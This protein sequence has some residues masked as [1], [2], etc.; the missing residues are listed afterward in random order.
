MVFKAYHFQILLRLILIVANCFLIVYVWQLHQYWISFYNLLLFLII[1]VYLLFRY[2]TRWQ[3][4]VKVFSNSV[5]HGDYNITYN[6]IDKTD[7][8]YDLYTML[9]SISVYVR[10]LKSQSEQ[11]N[12]YFQ[13]LVENAQ[14]GLVAYD[15]AGTIL[16]V[17]DEALR[18]VGAARLKSIHQLKDT[19]HDLYK[20]LSQMALRQPKLIRFGDHKQMK[21]SARLSEVV[22]DGKSIRLLSLINIKSELEEN[23]LQSWQDLISVLTHELMNSVT[24]INSLGGSMRKYLDRIVDNEEIVTK[25]KS[26][27]DVITRRSQ[28]LM[29][30]VDRYRKISAVPLPQL[31]LTDLGRLMSDVLLLLE[32]ELADI[33]IEY[34]YRSTLVQVDPSMIE[35]VF[36]N[37]I[38][39]A[40]HA[41]QGRVEK[42]LTILMTEAYGEVIVEFS[43]NGKG[44]S[45]AVM[46]KIFIPFFTTREEG[47][48]IGLTLSRQIIHR[49]KGTIEVTSEVGK[50][51]T[52]TL[53]FSKSQVNY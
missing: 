12:H 38:K 20:Q 45:D 24:P 25:A 49:H 5:R 48:G 19:A 4:D 29:N 21:L 11:Q 34:Q 33:K 9:N 50:G 51:A 13:Y 22:I 26:S 27:L 10:D 31:R 44:I 35:Q 17:N 6:L 28:M 3:Q 53:R 30:F 52:F 23:E 15:H 18:L 43:D 42:R 41:L 37:L 1:Q 2:L 39:N 14:V 8:H 40:A 7:P 32:D 46:D 47:S 36:I 16:L